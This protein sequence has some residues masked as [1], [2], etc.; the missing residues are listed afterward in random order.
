MLNRATNLCNS[1]AFTAVTGRITPA[2]PSVHVSGENLSAI[3][4]TRTVGSLCRMQTAIE[5]P[6]TPAPTTATEAAIFVGNCPCVRVHCHI[7]YP[8]QHQQYQK[9][10]L[11]E[12]HIQAGW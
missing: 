4:V 6:Q 8:G 1:K 3:T 11:A 7:D 12:H 2:A 5:S 10:A 9:S